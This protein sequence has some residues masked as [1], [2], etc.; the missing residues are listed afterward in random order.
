MQVTIVL[1]IEKLH[2]ER[3]KMGKK[4]NMTSMHLVSKKDDH[5]NVHVQK[6]MAESLVPKVHIKD[7]FNFRQI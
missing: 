6:N 5:I 4:M 2:M 3:T 1:L 7:F